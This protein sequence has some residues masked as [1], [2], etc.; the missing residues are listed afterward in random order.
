MRV[1]SGSTQVEFDARFENDVLAVRA[2]TRTPE[3]P[4][5]ADIAFRRYAAVVGRT[6]IEAVLYVDGEREAAD[7]KP[8]KN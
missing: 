5:R 3:G 1:T 7:R 8:E 6:G 2:R 4:V